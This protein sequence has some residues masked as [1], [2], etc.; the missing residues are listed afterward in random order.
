MIDKHTGAEK[1]LDAVGSISERFIFEA[2]AYSAPR[3]FAGIRR[4]AVAAVGI[5]LVLSLLL[6]T[7]IGTLTRT[8]EDAE[9][10]RPIENPNDAAT[11]PSTQAPDKND[12]MPE[13]VPTLAQTLEGVRLSTRKL[14]SP[15]ERDMLFDGQSRIIWRYTGEEEYRVCT[16]SKTDATLI[17]AA[18]AK[19]K[20][21]ERVESTDQ[22]SELDGIWICFG[23]GLVY[24]P[25]LETSDGNVGFGTL[26]DYE[27]ELE[28]SSDF[29]Q[30]IKNIIQKATN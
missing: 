14:I 1:L 7:L 30:R 3:R 21:F 8:E 5:T 20:D 29:V 9:P 22:S 17:G 16:M 27:S 19:K 6:A 24:S 11:A 4:L 2:E 23:D 26:F 12:A 15:I 18:L 10:E 25:Q 13:F 28:P